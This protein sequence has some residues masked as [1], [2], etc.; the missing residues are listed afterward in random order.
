VLLYEDSLAALALAVNRGSAAECSASPPTRGDP[1]A[2]ELSFGRRTATFRVD[3]STNDRRAEL[4]RRGARRA[5]RDR[6][7]AD[8]GRGRQGRSWSRPAEALLYSAVLRP[9]DRRHRCC[10]SRSRS[11]SA[12][13]SR[14]SAHRCVQVKWPNDVW[15]EERKVAGVLIEARPEGWA[16]IG[17]GLNV[18]VEPASSRQELRETATS[19]G[20]AG[21]TVTRR[22]LAALNER[23]GGWTRGCGRT[24]SSQR[25]RERDALAG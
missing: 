23:L 21:A 4:A 9:L 19:I 2:G 16:V 14:L 5:R 8:R 12:R 24:R 6:R 3:D 1:V 25:F 20:R 15:I 11:P 7:R 13:P 22:P 10:R 17:V 18:A